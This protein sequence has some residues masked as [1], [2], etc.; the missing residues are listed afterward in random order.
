MEKKNV[1]IV[2]GG[3]GFIAITLIGEL[4][5]QARVVV[6]ID[7]LSRG[8]EEYISQFVENDNFHFFQADLADRL[9]CESAFAFAEAQGEIDEVWHLA[10]NSDIPA[11]VADADVDLKDTFITTAEI[12]RSM[13]KHR[14]GEI[15]FASSSAIY[16]D[17]GDLEL[18]ENIGPL[19]PISNYGAMK[20]ASEAL[21]SAAA[22]SYLRKA[23]IFRFPNVVGVPATHGVILDFIGKLTVTR[24]ELQV[25]GNGTQKKAY[26]H[27]SDLV[28]AML[29]IHEAATASR[30]EVVNIGPV[31]H[32]VTVSWIAEQVV[33]YVSPNANIIYG[34]GNRGWVGDVPKFNYSTKKLQEYGWAP[35]MSSAEAIQR[36]IEEIVNQLGS[37]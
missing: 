7:N 27:V 19:L 35:K 15:C 21:I 3:A 23:C 25:L 37:S 8:K 32:G 24:G 10:A 12:L 4:L 1:S 26:L 29:T 14:V 22:E 20:L 5:K 34:E 13:K 31:D 36:A 30:V 16:G 11:G 18:H 6:A 28:L 33:S 17:L 9:Q 2:A